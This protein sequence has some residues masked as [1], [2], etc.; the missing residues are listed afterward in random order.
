MICMPKSQ[1]RDRAFHLRRRP[2]REKRVPARRLPSWEREIRTRSFRLI[3]DFAMLRPLTSRTKGTGETRS[4][5]ESVANNFS[6]T[7][8]LFFGPNSGPNSAH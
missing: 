5:A 1:S 3:F 4:R 7:R 6:P 2:A 8:M